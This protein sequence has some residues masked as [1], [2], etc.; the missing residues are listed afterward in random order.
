[1]DQL[2]TA[3]EMTF[4]TMVSSSASLGFGAALDVIGSSVP[5]VFTFGDKLCG[6]QIPENMPLASA[7]W[8]PVYQS[9]RADTKR[10]FKSTLIVTWMILNDNARWRLARDIIIP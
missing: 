10:G 4:L 6:A 3:L 5:H 2:A 7:H 1:M 9:Q 8:S